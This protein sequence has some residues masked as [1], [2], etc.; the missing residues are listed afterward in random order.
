M[1]SDFL[2]YMQYLEFIGFFAGYPLVYAVIFYLSDQKN[3]PGIFFSKLY[4]ILPYA[5]AIAGLLYMGLQLKN[6]Y[7]DYSIENIQQTIQHPFLAIWAVLSIAFLIPAL[8]KKTYSSL[9]HSLV[10]FILFVTEIAN[11][12]VIRSTDE[13]V[14]HNAMNIYTASLLFYVIASFFLFIISAFVGYFKRLLQQ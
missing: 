10:F 8:A 4:S 7:P 3:K 12:S 11:G 9:V 2:S 1:G 13:N 6:I 14:L 5:Y